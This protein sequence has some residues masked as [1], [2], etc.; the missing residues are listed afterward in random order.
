MFRH[1]CVIIRELFRAF[2]VTCESN[3]MVDLRYSWL[4]VCY[5]ETWYAPIWLDR[6]RIAIRINSAGTEE[7]PDDDT[8]VPK[9]VGAAE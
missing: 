3:A 2:W 1:V 5:V 4:C 6:L 9:H 7:L 8:Y